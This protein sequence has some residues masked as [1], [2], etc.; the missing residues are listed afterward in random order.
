MK[1]LWH[2]FNIR[3]YE[4]LFKDCLNHKMKSEFQRK[5]AY[6]KRKLGELNDA[7]RKTS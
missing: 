2:T 7:C 6:H 5:I 1:K 4:I 3:Y